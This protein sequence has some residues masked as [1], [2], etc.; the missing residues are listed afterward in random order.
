[1]LVHPRNKSVVYYISNNK[2]QDCLIAEEQNRENSGEL[3]VTNHKVNI[4]NPHTDNKQYC[5]KKEFSSPPGVMNNC[6]GIISH[7]CNAKDDKLENCKAEA[8]SYKATRTE[9]GISTTR[10]VRA[11]NTNPRSPLNKPS[12]CIHR[13]YCK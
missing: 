10:T 2:H 4:R 12:A 9:T 5:N 11:L 3:H 6:S 13:P 1:M 7:K 8:Y